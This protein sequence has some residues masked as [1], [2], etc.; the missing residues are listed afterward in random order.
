MHSFFSLAL[1][2]RQTD[3]PIDRDS[4]MCYTELDAYELNDIHI[5]L[6]TS[7]AIS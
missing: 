2:D 7:K 5:I 3:S 1:T 6:V 4:L